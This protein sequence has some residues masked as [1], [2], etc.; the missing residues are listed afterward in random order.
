MKLKKKLPAKRLKKKR[1]CNLLFQDDFPK[2]PDD[3]KNEKLV[4][5]NGT[6]SEI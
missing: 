4:E 2:D 3:G 6:Q 5:D 1:K